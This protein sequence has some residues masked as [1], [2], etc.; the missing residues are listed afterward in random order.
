MKAFLAVLV[1]GGLV[2]GVL[3][4]MVWWAPEVPEALL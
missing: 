1:M 2:M 3:G 4:A